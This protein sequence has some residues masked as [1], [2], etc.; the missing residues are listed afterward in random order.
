MCIRYAEQVE[1]A[2]KDALEIQISNQ[3]GPLIF[4]K[5]MEHIITIDG[6]GPHRACNILG[7]DCYPL[8]IHLPHSPH[9]S[10]LIASGP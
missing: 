9:P 1:L 7:G 10:H 4:S 5:D 3:H 2:F 6:S 8:G